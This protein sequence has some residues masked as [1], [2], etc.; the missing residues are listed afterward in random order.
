MTTETTQ[1]YD[2]VET[3]LAS[4]TKELSNRLLDGWAINKTNPGDVI[5]LYG[6]TFTVSLYRNAETVQRLRTKAQETQDAPKPDR[7]AIL[8]KARDAKAAKAG[9][10]VNT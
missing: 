7:G 6:G 8:A 3:N 10:K 2:I 1:N 4:Y 9:R 5:G